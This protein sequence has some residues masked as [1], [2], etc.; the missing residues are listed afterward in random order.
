M[1]RV[2]NRVGDGIH[3][4]SNLSAK[5]WA[6]DSDAPIS[7]GL[8]VNTILSVVVG[9]FSIPGRKRPRLGTAVNQWGAE[10]RHEAQANQSAA[11]FVFGL[12]GDVARL[13]GWRLVEQRFLDVVV[14]KH[15]RRT[16]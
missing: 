2:H 14:S 8:P 5:I 16:R 10:S 1:A 4:C 3:H 13:R 12:N 7:I 11:R 6:C 15:E 9:R